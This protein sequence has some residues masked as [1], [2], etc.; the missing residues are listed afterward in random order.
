MILN[1]SN[2]LLAISYLFIINEILKQV[3]G[4]NDYLQWSVH[5]LLGFLIIM[6]ILV[7]SKQKE[8]KNQVIAIIGLAILAIA[9]VFLFA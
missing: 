3:V 4:E 6:G 8:K 5:T 2:L 7:F 9:N 1:K